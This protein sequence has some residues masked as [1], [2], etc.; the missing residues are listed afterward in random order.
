M[1]ETRLPALRGD[2]IAGA[3]ASPPDPH[4]QLPVMN[5]TGVQTDAIWKEMTNSDRKVI[6]AFTGWAQAT[7]PSG[8][9]IPSRNGGIFQRDRYITPNTVVE[10]MKAAYAAVEQDDIVSGVA[11]ATESL[12]FSICSFVADD[13]DDQDIYNQIAADI[14]LDSRLREIWRELFTVSQVTIG[15]WWEKKT[16]H[17]RGKTKKGNE[18]R[19]EYKN[20]Q[21]PI[22][23]TILDPLK[24]VPVGTTAFGKE[25]LAYAAGRDESARFADIMSLERVDQDDI[26]Q[27]LLIADPKSKDGRYIPDRAEA[28]E[29]QSA[30]FDPNHLWLLNPNNVFRHTLTRSSFQRWAPVRMRSCFELLD[31]KQQL[32]QMERAH[33]IGGTNFIVLI[34]KGSDDMPAKP[35][36]IAHLQTEVRTVARVP[37]LVGDHRLKVEIITP[38]LDHT[39]RA[40]RFNTID[41][42]LTARLYQM[43]QLGNYSAGASGDDSAKLIKVVARGLESR[44]HMIR[45]S[46]EKSILKPLYDMND[47]LKTRPGLIFHPRAIA[48]DFDANWASFLLQLRQDRE[49]SRDTILTQFDL[50]QPHEALML[51]REAEHYDKIFQSTVAF[52]GKPGQGQ[53][54]DPNTGQPLPP[55]QVPPG[56][57]RNHRDNGGG[58]NN[59]GGRAPGTGQGQPAKNPGKKSDRGRKVAAQSE[60]GLPGPITVLDADGNVIAEGRPL[61]GIDFDALLELDMEDPDV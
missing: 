36:E 54:V 16:Y 44:R 39:L 58:S 29:I 53:P 26:V 33:L 8:G 51:E 22:D 46:I 56:D 60:E 57:P 61:P 52:S 20:L 9:A 34:T 28:Q 43:F 40:E 35:E 23:I 55:G 11:E 31:L 38:K 17:V 4:F 47:D 13:E 30:G 6:A 3:L 18:R 25:R 48:L 2:V 14:D 12:A 1:T 15:V 5:D 42:R 21:V 59:G 41:S 19:K 49:I 37:I 24:I 27:R 50:N 32:R 7:Q 10:Q 45:R